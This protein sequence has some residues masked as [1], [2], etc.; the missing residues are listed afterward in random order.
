LNTQMSDY[1][2]EYNMVE[3]FRK[4][5]LMDKRYFITSYPLRT[6]KKKRQRWSI[7]YNKYVGKIYTCILS[8]DM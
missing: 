2:E 4:K 5:D 6:G 3:K 8:V 1:E 7:K